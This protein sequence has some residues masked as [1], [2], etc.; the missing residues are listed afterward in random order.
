REDVVDA[1]RQGQFHIW[2]VRTVDEG[3]EIL[4]GAQAGER[5]GGGTWEP[6][7]VNASVDDPLGDYAP[8]TKRFRQSTDIAAT[9][10]ATP[11]QIG[12]QARRFR[13]WW[14]SIQRL[15]LWR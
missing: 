5:R 9:G 7:C 6:G 13:S 10:R 2:A 3:I 11:T 14:A 15:W 4:T 1:V 12:R 8:S